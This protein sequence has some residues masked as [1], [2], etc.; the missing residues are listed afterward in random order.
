MEK[1]KFF[2][3]TLR[4]LITSKCPYHCIYCHKEGMNGEVKELLNID[5]YST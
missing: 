1:L 3:N 4:L 2:N 5:Y